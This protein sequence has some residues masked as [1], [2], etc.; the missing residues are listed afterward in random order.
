MHRRWSGWLGLLTSI[1]GLGL[2][3]TALVGCESHTRDDDAGPRLDA[4]VSPDAVAPGCDGCSNS[5]APIFTSCGGFAGTTCAPTEY[6]DYPDG[7]YCGGDDSTGVCRPRPTECPDPGGV[8]V[9]GCDGTEYIGE[10]SAYLVG[11]DVSA[12]G[13]CVTTHAYR[14]AKAEADCGPADG[15]AWTFTLTTSRATCDEVRTDGS[16]VIS[17]WHALDSAAPDTTY[18]L[19][20]D[21]SGDGNAQVCGAPGEPCAPATGTIVVH[22]FAAGEVARF[23]FDIQTADGRRFAETNIEV[24]AFWC[25]VTS[26]GCG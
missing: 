9:C 26:P 19:R 16:L 3:G 11:V 12:I 21:F 13:P 15:P 14:T 6:C 20:S 2:A 18:E 7:S 24:A 4:I 23:D 10:C 1:A 5:D 8:T 22:T 17:V 25:R